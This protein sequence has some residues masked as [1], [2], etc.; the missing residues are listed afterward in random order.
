MKKNPLRSVL[1]IA[2]LIALGLCPMLFLMAG[3]KVVAADGTLLWEAPRL[4]DVSVTVGRIHRPEAAY[5][6]VP[7][8]RPTARPKPVRTPL[9][10]PVHVEI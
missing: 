5:L 3:M 8:N 9:R 4:P 7:P 2:G 10:R 1:N 6:T